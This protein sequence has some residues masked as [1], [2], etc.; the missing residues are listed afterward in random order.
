MISVF[1]WA[2]ANG[3]RSTWTFCAAIREYWPKA[4][5][6]TPL[7][8]LHSQIDQLADRALH[9]K[10]DIARHKRAV[11][12]LRALP[13]DLGGR[14]GYDLIDQLVAVEEQRAAEQVTREFPAFLK[15]LARRAE[16]S[17]SG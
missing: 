6:K 3:P 8:E 4:F 5:S 2:A 14:I 17:K 10:Q 16:Q 12:L 13:P 11:E 15:E 7:Q 9:Y 1:S